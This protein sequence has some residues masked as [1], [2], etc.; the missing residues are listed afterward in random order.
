MKHACFDSLER[1][2]VYS[3]W[4]FGAEISQ[5]VAQTSLL[6]TLTIFF[7]TIKDMFVLVAA[8]KRSREE[9]GG[10]SGRSQLQKLLYC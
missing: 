10:E 6:S 7:L 5:H 1:L 2:S 8:R 9:G 4:N 3:N